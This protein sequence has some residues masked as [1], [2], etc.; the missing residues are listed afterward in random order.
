MHRTA[1]LV[2]VATWKLVG[3]ALF[4]ALNKKRSS[5]GPRKATLVV[6]RGLFDERFLRYFAAE[7]PGVAVAATGGS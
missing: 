3:L 2:P 7:V 6:L 5:K 4:L 1:N